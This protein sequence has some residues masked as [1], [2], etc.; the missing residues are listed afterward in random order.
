M[1]SRRRLHLFLALAFVFICTVLPFLETSTFGLVDFDDYAYVGRTSI[2]ASGLS[3]KTIAQSFTYLDQAIWMPLTWMS[4]MLDFT[5]FGGSPG[6]M[7]VH[8]FLLHA[9]NAVLLL[10]LL[11]QLSVGAKSVEEPCR[12]PAQN[13]VPIAVLATLIWSL[14]PLRVE[15]VTW[16]A[17]RK[18]VLSLFWELLAMISWLKFRTTKRISFYGLSLLAFLISSFAKPSVMTFPVLM[19]ILDWLILRET[20]PSSLFSIF[21]EGESDIRNLINPRS[22]LPYLIPL[23]YALF[24][25]WFAAHAQDVG[26][27]MENMKGVPLWWKLLNAAVSYGIYLL[28]TV[29]PVDLAPECLARWPALPRFLLPA[30][31]LA[32]AMFIWTA[33]VTRRHLQALRQGESQGRRLF[34]ASVLWYSVA[35]FPFLGIAGFG[36]HAYADRF[37]YIPA[38]G[39]SI[40]LAIGARKLSRKA[41]AVAICATLCLIPLTRRQSSFW[42]TDET[43]YKQVLRADGVQ[44]VEAHMGLGMYYFE[45]KHD[46]LDL[47]IQSFERAKRLNPESAGKIG[48]LYVIA[49]CEAGRIEEA[50]TILRWYSDWKD[51]HLQS[52]CTQNTFV[53]QKPHYLYR[54]AK[55][56]WFA[57]QNMLNAAEEELADLERD[58]KDNFNYLYAKGRVAWISGNKQVAR[59]IWK[60]MREHGTGEYY[61]L[62]RFT[63]QL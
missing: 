40:L 56:I 49:L 54:T 11:M 9:C 41:S 60:Q 7:H 57:S 47:S 22:C 45:F 4:Y 18:D 36:Y 29:Y 62:Y 42:R 38:I 19:F 39:L 17:A 44:N 3:W 46:Q 5:L 63:E 25:G 58:F 6:G 37:T 16:V 24:L 33:S 52:D 13:V 21:H 8:S 59:D 30:F 31:P 12:Q 10:V 23:L 53:P 1:N 34:L 43:I 50:G 27:A 20:E 32:V 35:V 61:I 55:A 14:H 15:S 51:R 48:P 28:H 26:Q 2:V